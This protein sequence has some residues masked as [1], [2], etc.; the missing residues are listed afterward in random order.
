MLKKNCCIAVYPDLS[1]NDSIEKAKE[2]IRI[3]AENNYTEVFS[4]LH[5]PEY[6]FER[7]AESL[8]EIASAIKATNMKLSV[9]I[10][11]VFLSKVLKDN[12]FSQ[13]V[14]KIGI[15]ALRLD[16]DC[17][18]TDV[19]AVAGVLKCEEIILNTSTTNEQQLIEILKDYKETHLSIRSCHNFYPRVETGLSMTFMIKQSDLFKKQGIAVMACVP[20]LQSARGPLFSGL[21]TV[22]DHRT[23][24]IVKSALELI[25]LECI[26]A[27][28]IGDSNAPLG[29]LQTVSSIAHYKP[30]R[31]RILVEKNCS[32]E[33]KNILFAIAHQARMDS[34]AYQIR[35][36]TSR[37][38]A[39]FGKDIRPNNTLVR[40]KYSITIDNVKYGRYS[41]ELQINTVDKPSDSRVNVVAHVISED[42]WMIDYLL[43][44]F[45]FTFCEV[46]SESNS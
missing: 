5:M 32:I 35:S 3:A 27:I 40:K 14:K 1:R 43:K 37:E 29:D 2:Y 6:S 4:S 7:Q 36:L 12:V 41:G 45:D 16:N 46:N 33:E 26:D 44:G 19:I 23:L 39:E 11:Q 30:L 25:S 28:M 18:S 10:N 13:L 42:W 17:Q 24:P 31:L 20:S 15:D 22:E 21:P 38:Y 8:I 34:G 9:D